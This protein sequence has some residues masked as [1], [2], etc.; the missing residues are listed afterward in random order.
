LKRG[1]L[2]GIVPDPEL[3]VQ[4]LELPRDSTLLLY[5]D[6]VREATDPAG[7]MFG[8]AGLRAVLAE[9]AH[10]PAQVVC[11]RIF[12]RLAAHRGPVP[13]QD[14]MTLVTVKSGV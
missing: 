5:T 13:Q 9:S 3:D 12:Q 1:Q 4:R 6:G 7:N 8:D 11:D 2:L 14:D 10:D